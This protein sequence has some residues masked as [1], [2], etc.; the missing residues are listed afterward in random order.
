MAYT[1]TSPL[2]ALVEFNS[3][4]TGFND[5]VAMWKAYVQ[6]ELRF[7]VNIDIVNKI[8]DNRTPAN[9]A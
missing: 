7:Y 4:E 9:T 5:M 6:T 2:D 1:L 8:P 3:T